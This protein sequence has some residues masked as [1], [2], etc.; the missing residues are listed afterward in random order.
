MDFPF[1]RPNNPRFVA[2]CFLISL[3]ILYFLKDMGF[4]KYIICLVASFI[5][6]FLVG[7]LFPNYVKYFDR[8]KK[9]K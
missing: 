2:Q 7:K 8:F 3:P 4:E 5:V 1:I 6:E 9:R